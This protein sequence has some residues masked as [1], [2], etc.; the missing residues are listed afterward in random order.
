MNTVLLPAGLPALLADASCHSG[1]NH[2]P[3]AKRPFF[4]SR[5]AS[6]R[7]CCPGR[8]PR[9]GGEPPRRRHGLRNGLRTALAGSSLRLA[10]SSSRGSCSQAHG[11]GLAVP[12]RQPPTPGR[13]DAVA[14]GHRPVMP[15]PDGDFHPAME[16]PSQAHARGVYAASTS[17]SRQ[18]N[19]T[20][21]ARAHLKAA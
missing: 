20:G 5:F 14:F 21:H 2:P 12:L 6:A 1:S 13:H 7:L 16:A 11:Y 3:T 4:G 15:R 19:R 9:Q 10:E 18:P 8:L 17:A